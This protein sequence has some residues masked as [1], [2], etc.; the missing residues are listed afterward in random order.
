MKK[1]FHPPRLPYRRGRVKK[2]DVLFRVVAQQWDRLGKET[3]QFRYCKTQPEAEMIVE[4]F[5]TNKI[6][7]LSEIP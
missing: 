5:V 1:L 4:R 6:D 2:G 7:E 3:V